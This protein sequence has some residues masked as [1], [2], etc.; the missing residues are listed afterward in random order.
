MSDTIKLYYKDAYIQEFNATVNDCM[1]RGEKYAVI[2]DRTAFYP[3]GGGQPGDIGILQDAV[4]SD[5]IEEEGNILHI[6]DRPLPVGETVTGKIDFER[7]FDFMQQHSGEHIVSGLVHSAFGYNNVGFHMGSDVVTIDFDGLLT[8]DDLRRIETEA[9]RR[10]WNDREIEILYPDEQELAAMEYRSK[11]ELTGQ[12][13]I[14]VFPGTDA[15]ACCGTHVSRTG[16]IGMVKILSAVKFRSGVRV[17]MI[18]GRRVYD[19]LSVTADQNHRISVLLS[20]KHG[21]TADAVLR[22]QEENYRLRGEV[23]RLEEASYLAEAR[24]HEGEGSVL[25]FREGMSA[26]GVRKLTDA[27]MKT[28]KGCCAV[29]S[30][31][32]DGSFKYAMGEQGGDLRSFTK[33]MNAA[34]NGRGGGKPF[35]VQGSVKSTEEEIRRFFSA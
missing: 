17:E 15:C 33:E 8:E 27:V 4:V 24:L 7:R 2:L 19:Y 10:I 20:A 31:N 18:S 5:T 6:V 12:V 30:D 25:L 11:K 3:E 32:G 21:E 9:N 13:R 29:F 22:M 35:F 26:D 28:C 34:L 23:L 1:P 16:E 14:V